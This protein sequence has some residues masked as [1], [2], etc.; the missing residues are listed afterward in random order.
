M[1]YRKYLFG[2]F[3]S[4]VHIKPSLQAIPKRRVPEAVNRTDSYEEIVF[5]DP[6]FTMIDDEGMEEEEDDGMSEGDDES[7]EIIDDEYGDE[8]GAGTKVPSKEEDEILEGDIVVVS[9]MS[10]EPSNV[11]HLL[12]TKQV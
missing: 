5:D 7:L 1:C 11:P 10:K 12:K 9:P 6:Y 2:L 4:T 8:D 3:P